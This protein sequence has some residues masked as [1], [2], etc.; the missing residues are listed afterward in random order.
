MNIAQSLDVRTPFNAC[1]I[2]TT[3]ADEH[4]ACLRDW[5]QTYDQLSAGAFRGEFEEYCFGNIQLFREN[6]NQCLHES[7]SPVKGWRSVGVITEMEGQ[8][9]WHG[10][11]FAPDSIINLEGGRGLDFRAPKQHEILVAVVN[12]EALRDY[13][14]HV[15]HRDLS[16][17]P[18]HSGLINGYPQQAAKLRAFLT[19]VFNSLRAT[20]EML[21]HEPLRKA[22]EHAI[23]SSALE[24]IQIEHPDRPSTSG[25]T[26]QQ[27]V[28][29]ARAYMREH[30]EEP[31]CIEDLCCELRVSRR[32][33]QYS[34]QDVLN[35]NPI[36]FLRTMRLNG[37]R[38]ALKDADPQTDTVADIAAQWG[39]WHLSHFASEYRAMFEELPSET[40]RRRLS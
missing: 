31:I 14:L 15:E 32:T 28:E 5:E 4:A 11:A 2:E 12:E 19:T 37:V 9:W 10:D 38:R 29:R 39:F 22:L 8:G 25:M 16:L 34:F 7:G 24:A 23:F 18:P 40:L 17:E 3:D 35:L 30:I 20:P 6:I 26:R 21:T 13:A 27:I 36:K 1:L 33:L